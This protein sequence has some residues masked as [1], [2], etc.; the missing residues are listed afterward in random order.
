MTGD[1]S[2]DR[3]EL[4]RLRDELCRLVDTILERLPLWRGTLYRLAR[5]CGHPGCQC[6]RGHLHTTMV[7]SDRTGERQQ[8]FVPILGDLPRLRR[9]TAQYRRFRQARARLGK[10][11]RS[12]LPVIDRLEEAGLGMAQQQMPRERL[13]GDRQKAR[14]RSHHKDPVRRKR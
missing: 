3:K 6:A 9:L 13:L 7:L 11:F 2:S 1:P 8:T 14:S 5:R 4:L 12:M 10:L